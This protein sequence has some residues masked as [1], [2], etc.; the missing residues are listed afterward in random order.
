M[1][2]FCPRC[3]QPIELGY[4]KKKGNQMACCSECHTVVAA[5]YKK[6]SDRVYWEYK[7]EKA[8]P[9]KPYGGGCGTAILIVIILSI[10]IAAARCDWKVPYK[11]PDET[12]EEPLR[13]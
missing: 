2:V 12:L 10:V 11:P 7:F 1:K 8:L 4:L 13:N 3:N 6:D 9:K 5:T